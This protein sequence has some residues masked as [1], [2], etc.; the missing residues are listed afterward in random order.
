ML[1]LVECQT[2]AEE[3]PENNKKRVY[4][5]VYPEGIEASNKS[6]A[7]D[8]ARKQ[9]AKVGVLDEETGAVTVYGNTYFD[10]H[11][12]P[13][14]WKKYA[15]PMSSADYNEAFEDE[16]MTALTNAGLEPDYR[17][18]GVIVKTG[19]DTWLIRV[20]EGHEES[21]QLILYH[22]NNWGAHKNSCPEAP[23]FHR[24]FKG[25][26]TIDELIKYMTDHEMKWQ[27][28]NRR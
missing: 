11:A 5:A 12:K 4:K 7:I 9:L 19:V 26:Y 21:A 8:K 27:G 25:N 16:I 15:T 14:K 2:K 28:K 6:E 13:L 3:M 22:K 10:F 23:G 24:Q 17:M 1:Y 20:L 18:N